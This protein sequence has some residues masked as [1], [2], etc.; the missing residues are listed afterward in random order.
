MERKSWIREVCAGIALVLPCLGLAQWTWTVQSPLP[1]GRDL[2]GVSMASPTNML[3]VGINRTLI[4]TVDAWQTW[5]YRM[6]G[7]TGG[8]PFYAIEHR[9]PN[10]V[11]LTGNNNDAWRSLNGGSSWLPMLGVPA[12]SWR[13]I[14]FISDSQ[15]FL[16]AN[17]AL[18]MTLNGGASW[19]VQSG[20]PN[21]PVVYG[22]DFRDA[23]VGLIGGYQPSTQQDGIF[24]TVDGGRT[25]TRKHANSVNAVLW[26]DATTALAID[27]TTVIRSTDSG[28]SWFGY[29]FGI[30]TGLLAMTRAGTSNVL[31]GVS[32]K[33]DIWRSPNG[34]GFW[35]LVQ[36]GIGDLPAEWDV[37]FFDASNGMVVGQ[38]GLMYRT[39][40]GGI[41]WT[42]ANNGCGA[43]V[44]D[45]EMR[46]A[47]YGMA[48]GQNGYLW[49][50]TNGGARWDV[51]KLEV[52]GQIFGRDESLNAIDLVDANFAAAAGPGG[53]VFKTLDSGRSWASIGYPA[54][55]DQFWINDVEF[56]NAQRGWVAGQ[57]LAYGHSKNLYRTDDG[58]NTWTQVD[59]GPAP[60][61][62]VQFADPTHGW[63][64]AAGALGLRT[65]DGGAT[66]Q[67]MPLPTYWTSP[68]ISRMRFAD[69]QVGWAAGW[70]GYLAKTVDGGATWQLMSAAANDEVFFDVSVVSRQ[71]V[72]LSGQNRTTGNGFILHSTNGGQS[73]TRQNVGTF[74]LYPYRICALPTGDVW[75]GATQGQITRRVTTQTV[76]PTSFSVVS[77]LLV[78]GSLSDLLASDNLYLKV[79]VNPA[80]DLIGDPVNVQFETVSPTISPAGIV[81]GLESHV[82]LRGVARHVDLWDYPAGRWVRVNAAPA[83][84]TDQLLTVTAPMPT[85]RFV[86]AGTRRMRARA[87]FIEVAS[88]SITPWQ[89]WY[90]QVFWRVSP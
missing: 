51:D 4:Q 10:L 83:G 28:E 42:Q 40:D 61:V 39:T 88:D 44:T 46:D 54:L 63:L 41:T 70:W 76:A 13:V 87:S 89:S 59:L 16:G 8:D 52:T 53:T 73:W 30:D 26:W 29:G 79:R 25:W 71:E 86:E 80:M 55:P 21:C 5:A 1:T 60:W 78:S 2:N 72:W 18:A 56:I 68:T 65:T 69:T 23:N 48:V 47:Q 66:W 45:L 85:G 84:T 82:T 38:Y 24:K 58:G 90:D 34:G 11:F 7:A 33:G 81:F 20:Y 77:G 6:Y 14:D 36:R 75:T 43:Q 64:S 49:R 17:G 22:M 19:L 74:P 32:G 31:V 12:G 35:V 9:N 37:D 27:G 3:V 62:S 15:V 57:D 50:T 67:E